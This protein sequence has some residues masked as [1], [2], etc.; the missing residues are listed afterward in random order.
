MAT[1]EKF[2]LMSALLRATK[3]LKSKTCE[4]YGSESERNEA[5]AMLET[6]LVC[7]RSDYKRKDLPIIPFFFGDEV[8]AKPE[9]NEV[10]DSPLSTTP[11]KP[12]LVEVIRVLGKGRRVLCTHFLRYPIEEI[13][14]ELCALR[15]GLAVTELPKHLQYPL[16]LK[17]LHE[18]F[19]N[20]NLFRVYAHEQEQLV[21]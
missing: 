17:V 6:V 16:A 15:P 9:R 8:Y 5:L 2:N 14:A 1:L 7:L 3:A 13:Q 10:G 12:D 18:M 20:P 11:A 21:A 19:H 4:P